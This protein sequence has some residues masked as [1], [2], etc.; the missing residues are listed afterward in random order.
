M[1]CG[2]CFLSFS[3]VVYVGHSV[4][5]GVSVYLLSSKKPANF[6]FSLSVPQESH[7]WFCIFVGF[8]VFDFVFVLFS[9]SL[10]F[11]VLLEPQPSV[12]VPTCNSSNSQCHHLYKHATLSLHS[13]TASTLP[14]TPFV[15]AE[16]IVFTG[17]LF[18]ILFLSNFVF[19]PLIF[20]FFVLVFLIFLGIRRSMKET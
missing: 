18:F 10:A 14:L 7:L 20:L 13:M 2:F 17:V 4:C 16:G 9:C 15:Q 1:L 6:N 8:V 19:V 5:F 12:A 3:C 11:F